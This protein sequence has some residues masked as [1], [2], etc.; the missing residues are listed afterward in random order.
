MRLAIRLPKLQLAEI[1]EPTHSYAGC[2]GGARGGGH[3]GLRGSGFLQ[4][5]LPYR[6][7]A[8]TSPTAGANINPLLDWLSSIQ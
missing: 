1:S 2:R 4:M 5:Q 6:P 7:P 8:L 3:F